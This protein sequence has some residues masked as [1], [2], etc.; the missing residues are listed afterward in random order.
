MFP[1]LGRVYIVSRRS[2]QQWRMN[3][4]INL[5]SQ[6]FFSGRPFQL[7]VFCSKTSFQDPIFNEIKVQVRSSSATD[8]LMLRSKCSF[9]NFC[10]MSTDRG[11]TLQRFNFFIEDND[12]L[13]ISAKIQFP[14]SFTKNWLLPFIALG[15]VA[16]VN[17]QESRA[18]LVHMLGIKS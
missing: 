15:N 18:F 8:C 12:I 1:F 11:Q 5:S 17:Y 4:Q 3:Y 14:C 6:V 16:Y 7:V 2:D 9:R 10:M 13:I